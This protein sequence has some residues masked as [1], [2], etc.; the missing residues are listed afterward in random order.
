[1]NVRIIKE[2]TLT[3][4]MLGLL[5]ECEEQGYLEYR[6]G[7]QTYEEYS[8][9]MTPEQ[10]EVFSP[11]RF[12]KRNHNG[13]Y[14]VARTLEDAGFL[15]FDHDSWHITYLLSELGKTVLGHA[16]SSSEDIDIK[17]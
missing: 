13:T 5:N 10:K 9:E 7:A 17:L 4:D 6:E 14:E 2:I 1:M 3:K 11:E 15:D 16:K 12:A 8:S